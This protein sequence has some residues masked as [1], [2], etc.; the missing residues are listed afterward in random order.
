MKP[1]E[2]AMSVQPWQTPN[3]VRLKVPPTTRQNGFKEAPAIP[4]SEIDADVLAALCDTFRA[5]VFTKAGKVDPQ[6]S[7]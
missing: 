6:E 5:E 1:I 2:Q 7:R 3:Y 4:L